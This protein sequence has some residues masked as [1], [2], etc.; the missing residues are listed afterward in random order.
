M[1]ML[2][3]PKGKVTFSQIEEA[4][5]FQDNPENPKKFTI[6]VEF[7]G[8]DAKKLRLQLIEMG[9]VVKIIDDKLKI[10]FS[11]AEKLGRPRLVDETKKEIID[12]P[13]FITRG[14]EVKVAFI[15]REFPMGVALLLESVMIIGEMA[16]NARQN[17]GGAV[18][19]DSTAVIDKEFLDVF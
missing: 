15:A 13:A 18:K 6:S 8:E 12:R 7:E 14:T 11:R 10:T 17:K 1:T 9:K 4:R 5:S 3:T 2:V 19:L 16:P